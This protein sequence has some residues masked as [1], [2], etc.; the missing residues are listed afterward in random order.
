MIEHLLPLCRDRCPGAQSRNWRHESGGSERAE[1]KLTCP[2]GP[3]PNG[4][5]PDDTTLQTG[6]LVMFDIRP[7]DVVLFFCE[8]SYL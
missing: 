7:Y 6:S 1:L 3:F 8:S 2:T 5:A 4:I